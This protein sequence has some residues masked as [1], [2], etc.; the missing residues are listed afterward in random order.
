MSTT[1][2]MYPSR[3]LKKTNV[4]IQVEFMVLTW[5]FGNDC[6]PAAKTFDMF[7]NMDT[8]HNKHDGM[9]NP[10]EQLFFWVSKYLC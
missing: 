6:N 4:Y 7:L 3:E 2:L 8:K 10:F 5:W 1:R 9:E